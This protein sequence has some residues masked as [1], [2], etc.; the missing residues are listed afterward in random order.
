MGHGFEGWFGSEADFASQC[1]RSLVQCP[2][3]GDSDITKKLSA[4]RLNF[5]ARA[6]TET[7]GTRVNAIEKV[8]ASAE[9]TSS[10]VLGAWMAIS[11]KLM[12]ETADVG[13]EFAEEARKMHYGESEQRAIR[14]HT[15]PT[16]ARSLMEEGIDVLPL[17]VPESLKNSLQ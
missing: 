15:T 3:C 9:P 1:A 16:E 17:F 11:Q 8:P 6:E 13:G 14:G 10:E 5:L 7:A 4:P 2:F 12:A